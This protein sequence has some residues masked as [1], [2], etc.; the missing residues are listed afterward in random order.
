MVQAAV[1]TGDLVGSTK[2]KPEATDDAIDH[3][4]A[5][6]AQLKQYATFTRF[7]GDGWQLYLERPGLA[8]AVSVL[9]ISGLR[10]SG[11]LETRVSIG[12]GG[13][14]LSSIK[15]MLATRDLLA[16]TGTAFITSGR[17]LDDMPRDR[18]LVLS[19]EG[20][21]RLHQRLVAIL[22]ERISTWSRE[23]AEVAAMALRP[24]D[25]PTQSTM[26]E[27]LGISRQAVAARL[28]ASGFAGVNAAAN[29]FLLHFSEGQETH[30]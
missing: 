3:I 27:Q 30:A 29:D 13:A 16:A 23:Q 9:I 6:A 18:R 24:N 21:D 20:V 8:L 12:L 1:L 14:Y 19:G 5:V 17:A 2:A 25:K 15:N 26:A 7:R 11:K 4:S 10:A 28:K 22:D